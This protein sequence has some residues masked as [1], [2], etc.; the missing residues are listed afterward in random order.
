MG[1][2]SKWAFTCPMCGVGRAT[3]VEL[4]AHM[5]SVHRPAPSY[6]LWTVVPGAGRGVGAGA[7]SGMEA[8]RGAGAGARARATAGAGAGAGDGVRVGLGFAG[9]EGARGAAVGRRRDSRGTA[10]DEI[11]GNVGQAAAEGSM[12]LATRNSSRRTLGKVRCLCTVSD[13]EQFC[14]I[15]NHLTTCCATIHP[16]SPVNPSYITL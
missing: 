16:C 7:E 15:V 5:A 8:E 9:E 3:A 6:T 10:N 4:A 13:V 12:Q 11:G 14:P 2:A 1:L